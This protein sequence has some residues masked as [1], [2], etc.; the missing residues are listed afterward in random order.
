MTYNNYLMNKSCQNIFDF[1]CFLNKFILIR[2]LF[3]PE[4]IVS[5]SIIDK[6][7]ANFFK[8]IIDSIC[9]FLRLISFNRTPPTKTLLFPISIS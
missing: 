9:L 2:P 7:Y 6:E 5:L 1:K 3:V 8:D 4:I